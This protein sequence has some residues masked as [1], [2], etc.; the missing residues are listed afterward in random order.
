V[1]VPGGM[2]GLHPGRR[3][4]RLRRGIAHQWRNATAFY[5]I[6]A[7]RRRHPGWFREDLTALFAMLAEGRIAPVVAE[8]LPL[9]DVWRHDVPRFS[10]GDRFP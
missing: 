6:G 4:A 8:V 10:P 3:A 7:M 9:A 5:S 2:G 1:A